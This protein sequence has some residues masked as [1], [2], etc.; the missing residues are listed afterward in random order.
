MNA[1]VPNGE[2]GMAALMGLEDEVVLECCEKQK[3]R[4]APL[5][6]MHLAR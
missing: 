1:A 4:S 6:T 3:G 2:G 5:T